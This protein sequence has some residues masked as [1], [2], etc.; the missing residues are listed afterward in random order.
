MQA[1]EHAMTPILTHEL[2]PAPI[3]D[4]PARATGRAGEEVD[5]IGALLEAL[6]A[7]GR[8]RL[9]ERGG[10]LYIEPVQDS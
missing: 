5:V 6:N 2:S 9:I 7:P 8:Y 10:E 3:V 4:R 1:R